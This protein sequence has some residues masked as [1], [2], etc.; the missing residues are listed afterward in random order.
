M[1]YFASLCNSGNGR[2]LDTWHTC[3]AG[4]AAERAATWGA[5]EGHYLAESTISDELGR[6]CLLSGLETKGKTWG[7][8]QTL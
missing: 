7:Y 8:P 4:P 3:Q 6:L 1:F 5:G 2:F